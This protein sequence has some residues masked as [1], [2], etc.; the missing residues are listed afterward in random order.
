MRGGS[1]VVARRTRIS[2][3]PRD[4]LG[5]DFQEQVI[6]RY[7]YSGAPIGKTNERDSLDLDR[8]HRRSRYCRQH[9]VRLGAAATNGG[10]QII[11]RPYSHNDGIR[12]TAEQWPQ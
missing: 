11:R 8:V 2:L 10:V 9:H 1:Y 7:K 6:G 4:R 12:F 5:I 3:E